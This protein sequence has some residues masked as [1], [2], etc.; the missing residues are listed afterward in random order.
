VTNAIKSDIRP[1]V[2]QSVIKTFVLRKTWEE[3]ESLEIHW[4]VLCIVSNYVCLY[5][6]ST[7]EFM[8]NRSRPPIKIHD[9]AISFYKL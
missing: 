2:V 8:A 5:D 6:R 1:I 9:D 4:H 7:R 3:K